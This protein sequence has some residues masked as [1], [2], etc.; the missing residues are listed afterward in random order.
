MDVQERWPSPDPGEELAA[1][2][3]PVAS[4]TRAR[5]SNALVVPTT[6]SRRTASTLACGWVIV[7]GDARSSGEVVADCGPVVV[8]WS[9]SWTR[10]SPWPARG[11]SHRGEEES[12]SG[13]AATHWP[14]VVRHR[15]PVSGGSGGVQR[16]VGERGG[17]FRLLSAGPGADG[18]IA[19]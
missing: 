1:H 12:D 3:V 15:A 4:Q 5:T 14:V 7:A 10:G 11:E 17:W 18:L 16:L 8:L 6:R 2:S 9:V 19:P 13:H